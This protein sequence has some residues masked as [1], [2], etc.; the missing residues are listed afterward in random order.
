MHFP[1]PPRPARPPGTGGRPPRHGAAFKLADPR[2]LACPGGGHP[3]T[4]TARYG[5]PPGLRPGKAAPAAGLPRRV[6]RPRWRAA[7]R[8]GHPHPAAG[9]SPAGRPQ[10]RA[11]VAM[12]LTRRPHL[13]RRGEP[14][15]AGVPAPLRYRTH[16]QVLQAGPRLNPP[17]NCATRPPPTGGPG[18]SSPAIPSSGLPG[19]YLPPT[20]GYPGNGPARPAASPRPGSGGDSGTSARHCPTWPAR[21][22]QANPAPAARPDRRTGARPPATTWARSSN[23]TSPRRKPAGRRVK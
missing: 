19:A 4:E 22:N 5:T 23:E 7:H 21:R 2:N 8:R 6:G 9:R 17:G 3:C 1:A 12:V 13:R 10:P 11:A 18:S 20:C 14:R 15:L 16:V